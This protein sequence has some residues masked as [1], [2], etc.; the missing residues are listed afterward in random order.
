MARPGRRVERVGVHRPIA[1]DAFEGEEYR[2][3]QLLYGHLH[4]AV[5]LH[6]RLFALQSEAQS[7]WA[8]LDRLSVGVIVV[9]MVIPGEPIPR[10]G[11]S[12]MAGGRCHCN[13]ARPPVADMTS[14]ASV[15]TSL[16]HRAVMVMS[17]V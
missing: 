4:R 14:S 10:S 16:G 13:W 15:R 1:L 6:G 8:A 9:D 7:G 17:R 11:A 12:Q 5:E 2:L 3:M